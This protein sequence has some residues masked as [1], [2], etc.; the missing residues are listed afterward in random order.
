M[1]EGGIRPAAR[2]RIVILGA[3]FAG[4]YCAQALEKRLRGLNADVLLID[5]HNYFVFF[6]LLIEAGT[7]SL[8]PRHAIVPIRAFLKRTDFLMTNVTGLDPAGKCMMAEIDGRPHHVPY[9][10]LVIAIGSVTSTPP[11][12]GVR[13]HGWQI[14]SLGDAVNLR[15][16]AIE[17]LERASAVEDPVRRRQL[18][19]FVVVGGNF[20]G[21]EVAGELH[22]LLR[23]GARYYRRVSR[24]DLRVTLIE[25]S[26]RV[27]AALGG[28]L[29][30]FAVRHLRKRG[31]EVCLH[32]SVAAI[33]PGVVR[34]HDGRA[35][36]AETAIWCAGIQPNPLIASLGLPLDQRGYI[37]CDRDL[38]VRGFDH[39]WAIGDCAVNIDEQGKPYPE[40]A[41]HAVQEGAHVARNLALA[42]R[43]RPTLPCNLVSRGSLA[44]IGCRTGVANVFGFKL[45][46][47]WAWWLWRTVYL[48]KMPGLA[49]KVRVA[50]DWTIDL[51]FSRDYV[52]LGVHERRTSAPASK[53]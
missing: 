15:D 1:S 9:D 12:P 45:A 37:V 17:M 29:S 14:K 27:L 38:R 18:L 24:D 23:G 19:H 34:L 41:Q 50:L 20:T 2:R 33:E 48:F 44:A 22:D 8:E 16:R 30:D 39:L 11:I 46:G 40:T 52:Q 31:I 26:P 49:R 4:A 5:R 10:H 43:G 47:F 42:L 36:N 53:C 7:G 35:M 25:R 13:E 3:G 51:I 28:E 6:P 32:T 21:V